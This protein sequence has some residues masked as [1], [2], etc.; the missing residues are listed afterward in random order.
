MFQSKEIKANVARYIKQIADVLAFVNRQMI[1]I[2]KTNDLLRTIEHNLGTSNRYSRIFI[3]KARIFIVSTY[4]NIILITILYLFSMLFFIQMSRSCFRC[5][6]DERLRLCNGFW[7][8]K[9]TEF[10]AAWDQFKISIYQVFLWLWWSPVG[11]YF[12]PNTI[13]TIVEL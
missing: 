2:F 4:V 13:T 12:R 11:R 5:L 1:L 3:N 10:T 9:R 7:C 8:R 6:N